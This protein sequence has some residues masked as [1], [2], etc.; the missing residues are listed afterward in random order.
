MT[1]WRNKVEIRE[2]L[3]G[4]SSDESVAKVTKVLIPQ[5]QRILELEEKKINNSSGLALNEEFVESFKEL[6][7]NFKWVIDCVEKEEDPEDYSY[8]DWC[9]A[10]NNYLTELYD[11][12][13]TVTGRFEEFHKEKFLWVG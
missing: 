3:T 9:E 2:Q 11:M 12:G 5:L 1:K 10:F 7:E 6:V 4:D 8:D 13:D